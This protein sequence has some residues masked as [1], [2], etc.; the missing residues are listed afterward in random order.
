M[1]RI[2]IADDHDGTRAILRVLLNQHSGWEVC[3]EASTGEET[4]QKCVEL[5][6]DVVV[7]DWVM[8]GMDSIELTRQIS[9][10]SPDTAIV[11][12]SFYDMPELIEAAKAAGVHKV[13]TKNIAL[14]TA[15][16]EDVLRS[17]ANRLINPSDSVLQ[18]RPEPPKEKL[19]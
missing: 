8:P 6:P 3:G 11:I 5:K 13:A 18:R 2:L 16:I 7:K 12:F 19:D 14:L 15:A 17:S 1:P 9:K 10:L 4:L